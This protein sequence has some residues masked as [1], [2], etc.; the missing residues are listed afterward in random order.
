MS[1]AIYIAIG[2]GGASILLMIIFG[3]TI[4]LLRRQVA[5]LE[6]AVTELCHKDFESKNRIDDLELKLFRTVGWVEG[7]TGRT[8]KGVEVK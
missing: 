4:A 3:I 6:N 5:G 2:V 8:I 7:L 1:V